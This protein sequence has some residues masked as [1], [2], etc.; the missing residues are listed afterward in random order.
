MSALLD[1]DDVVAGNARAEIE[2]T[3]LRNR[4]RTADILEQLARSGAGPHFSQQAVWCGQDAAY[5]IGTTSDDFDAAV[6]AMGKIAGIP[7]KS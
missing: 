6:L 1:L 7:A 3:E 2:L 5:T 4:A